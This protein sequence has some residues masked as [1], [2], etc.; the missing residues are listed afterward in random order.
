[1][2]EADATATT[3]AAMAAPIIKVVPMATVITIV[4]AVA[5]AEAVAEA[6]LVDSAFAICSSFYLSFLSLEHP[7]WQL[8]RVLARTSLAVRYFSWP[9]SSLEDRLT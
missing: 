2:E 9:G 5:K 4:A 1:M 7:R 8:F 3:V 6:M